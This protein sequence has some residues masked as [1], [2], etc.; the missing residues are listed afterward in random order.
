MKTSEDLTKAANHIEHYG[1]YNSRLE[2][3][4]IRKEQPHATCA[5]LAITSIGNTWKFAE[6]LGCDDVAMFPSIKLNFVY[7]WNDS[8]DNPRYVINTLREAAA[9]FAAKGE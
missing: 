5:G 9:H 2:A 3:F 4:K 1:W 6:Y 8:Q 7:N